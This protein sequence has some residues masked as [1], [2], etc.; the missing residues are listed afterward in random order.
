MTS[1]QKTHKENLGTQLKEE[2]LEAAPLDTQT[3][4]TMAEKKIA[5]Y[6]GVQAMRREIR[7]KQQ[8]LE[9]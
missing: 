6:K 5:F 4:K 8:M 9:V 3:E 1:R 7:M 2:N